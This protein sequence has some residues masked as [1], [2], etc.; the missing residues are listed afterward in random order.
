MQRRSRD[1]GVIF[2]GAISLMG[3]VICLLTSLVGKSEFRRWQAASSIQEPGDLQAIGE[4]GDAVIVGPIAPDTLAAEEGLALYERWE[5]EVE[6]EDDER[7]SRWRH[8]Y[9]YDHKPTFELLVGE[10]RVRVRSGFVVFYNPREIMTKEHVK[11]KGFALGDA[12]T[13]LGNVESSA[14]PSA[15]QAEYICGGE[16]KRCMK[17][18]SRTS[19]GPAIGAALMFL[20]GGG[21]VWLSIRRR[22]AP[23]GS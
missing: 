18:L 12:V 5:H 3:S 17:R 14:D 6:Y 22:K 4:G 1:I 8:N 13:V 10:Q 2:V 11:L 21:L 9:D 15:I 16:R 20:V 7:E 23:A 19:I